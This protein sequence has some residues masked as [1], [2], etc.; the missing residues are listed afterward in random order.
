MEKMVGE[1]KERTYSWLQN[2]SWTIGQLQQLLIFSHLFVHWWNIMEAG[3]NIETTTSSRSRIYI[4]NYSL[5]NTQ[6]AEELA[7]V[8]APKSI[9]PCLLE[10]TQEV[11]VMEIMPNK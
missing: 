5:P 2:V 10:S 6:T 4:S 9:A 7:Y 8:Q 11:A 1:K 3:P